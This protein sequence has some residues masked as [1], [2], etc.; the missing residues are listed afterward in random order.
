MAATLAT[1]R[2]TLA[3][4][5]QEYKSYVVMFRG[6]CKR[7]FRDEEE[8]MLEDDGSTTPEEISSIESGRR[9]RAIDLARA[10]ERLLEYETELSKFR[11]AVAS[12]QTFV[13]VQ[14]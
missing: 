11:D 3:V 10:E 6:Q 5:I 1:V 7:L 13:V 9:Q 4:Q 2:D 8:F 14:A 12:G